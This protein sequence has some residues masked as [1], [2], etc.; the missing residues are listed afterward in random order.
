V[1]STKIAKIGEANRGKSRAPQSAESK[2]KR[3]QK[4]AGKTRSPEAMAKYRATITAK[5]AGT[6]APASQ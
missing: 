3:R 1:G 6:K 2:E 4:L 5:K